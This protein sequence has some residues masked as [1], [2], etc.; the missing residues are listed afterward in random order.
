[1]H[2]ANNTKPTPPA[3][4]VAP[5]ELKAIVE[6]AVRGALA[7]HGPSAFAQPQEAAIAHEVG[8]AVVGAYEG[9]FIENVS[10]FSRRVPSQVDTWGGWVSCD[11]PAWRTGPDTS[12]ANDLS[13]AR[14]IIAGLAGEA[15]CRL[16]KPGSSLDELALSQ[17]VGLNAATKLADPQLS[18]DAYDTFAKRLWHEQVWDTTL[19][20]LHNNREP[21][22]RLAELLQERQEIK[23]KKLRDV[24]AQIRRR[25]VS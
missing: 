9:L 6:S 14:M 24:L 8:H 16:D 20:I 10:V 2:S 15:I 7:Q 5:P 22:Q 1:M 3:T 19:N 23:G 4:S 25:E 21:F 12:A 13:A 11:G 18:A 17:L